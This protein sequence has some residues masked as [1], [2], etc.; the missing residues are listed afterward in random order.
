MVVY[1]DNTSLPATAAE[2]RPC[3]NISPACRAT[4]AICSS[5]RSGFAAVGPC[6]DRQTDGHRTVS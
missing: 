4:A 1:F 3:S 6:W 5:S 2:R